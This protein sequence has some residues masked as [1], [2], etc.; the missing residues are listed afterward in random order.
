MK[1]CPQCAEPVRAAA[2]VCRYCHANVVNVSAPDITDPESIPVVLESEEFDSREQE[3][4]DFRQ[5][6]ESKHFKA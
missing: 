4:A 3:L 5:E 6:R 2:R 1:T